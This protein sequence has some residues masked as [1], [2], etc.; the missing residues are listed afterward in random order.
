MNTRV[1]LL[2][3]LGAAVA[4]AFAL[5]SSGGRPAAPG[6]GTN[7]S[8]PVGVGAERPG[9]PAGA[10]DGGGAAEGRATPFVSAAECRACH[11]EVYEEWRRSYHAMAWTDPMVQALSQGFRMTECIDCHAPQPIHLTGV[12]QRVAPRQ[13][14]RSDGVDCLSCHLLEDGVSVAAA[15]DVDTSAVAGACRPRR[16][17]TFTTSVVCAGC[18]NQHETVDELLASGVDAECQTCHMEETSR[19]AGDG[20]RKGRSH[21]FPGAHDTSMLQ[22]AVSLAVRVESGKV[23]AQVENVGAAH[24]TP[25]DARHR[26]YNVWI[27]AWDARGNPVVTDQ[28]MTDGEFRLYYRDDF[29]ESTQLVHG[30]PRTASWQVPEGFRGRVRVRLTYALNPEELAARRVAELHQQEVEIP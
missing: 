10:A 9:G 26:S 13:H 5:L 17:E 12:D 14:G 27:S 8:G 24:K 6:P 28:A 19:G 15:A 23:L 20:A 2:L 25:T 1:V 22:R 30:T 18:H 7:A 4:G 29:K 11:E 21:V 3:V 16:S